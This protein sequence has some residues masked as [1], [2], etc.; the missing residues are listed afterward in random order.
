[1]SVSGLG[2]AIDELFERGAQAC[3]TGDAMIELHRLLARLDAFV[4]TAAAAFDATREWEA[5]GARSAAAWLA[6]RCRL[7]R[8]SARRRV[9]LGRELRTL[10]E[11][12][13]AWM[14]G[15]ISEAHV[16]AIAAAR[17]PDTASAL[18]R[19]EKLLVDNAR[20]L[21]FE[22]FSTTV[23]YWRQ[24]A[25]PDSVEEDQAGQHS[26]RDLYLAHSF[27]GR[28]LGKLTLD[29]ISGTIVADEL[30]RLERELFEAEW[31]AARERT[32][33]E[34]TVGD[35]D[36]TPAQRRADAL[37]E[38]ATRSRTAPAGGRR[39]APL[40]S[41]LVGYETLHGR[42]CELADG[43][44]IT[45][46][47]LL[48]WLDRAYIERA[49]FTPEGRVEVSATARLYTGATRRALELRDRT[50]THDLCDLPACECEGDHIIP[51][52][53]GGPTTQDNGQLRC[54][55]H[56]RLRNPRAP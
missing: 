8:R 50:C 40:F 54:G 20:H 12:E 6:T 43:S 24:L 33:R 23:A 4:T 44:V 32:G 15:E 18:A 11:C 34:P 25:D 41:V 42:I 48:P 1:M 51:Y 29:A 17:G 2:D 47:A 35:L 7:P 39:P 13:T 49:V 10:P 52:A 55:Y 5:D 31:A 28:W 22:A 36:R 53:S 30:H 26:H 37:V 3:S 16:T 56:N 9:C 19:D 45:P 21:R 27:G 14:D 38:M 46:G